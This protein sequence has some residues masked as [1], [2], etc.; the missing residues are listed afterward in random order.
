[1]KL[2]LSQSK[3]TL[4]CKQ[5]L[6]SLPCVL[7]YICKLLCV[8]QLMFTCNSTYSDSRCYHFPTFSA[9][10]HSRSARSSC[11]GSR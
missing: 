1:L 7:N 6:G 2:T 9:I 4:S 8:L 10:Y 3:Y 5:A 11:Q